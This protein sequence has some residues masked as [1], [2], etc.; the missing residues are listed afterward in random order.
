[1][2]DRPHLHIEVRKMRF[3]KVKSF[4][5]EHPAGA[6]IRICLTEKPVPFTFLRVQHA[7]I[8]G[9][10]YPERRVGERTSLA[11]IFCH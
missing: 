10:L 7:P 9:R 2:R 5:Q 3:R 6:Q 8:T 11:L 4:V 1:M